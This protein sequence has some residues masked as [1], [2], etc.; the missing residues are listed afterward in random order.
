MSIPVPLEK[1]R[2]ALDE[3]GDGAYLLTVSDHVRPHPVHRPHPPLYIAANSEDSL[4]SA[5]RLGLPT[6]ASFFVPVAELERRRDL[7]RDTARG[8]GRP[9][10]E[11]AALEARGWGMRVVHVAPSR[12]EAL[13]AVEAPFMSYQG[14]M[15]M[16]RSDRTG[17][18][19]PNSFD[20]TLLRL[21][22]FQ[23]YLSDGWAL[24]GT[25]A[26]V[27]EGLQ[28]FLEATGS[29]VAR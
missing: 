18:S 11:I 29:P 7:Y 16:L 2:A 24:I 1:L 25:A 17:G 14:K 19:V 27:R 6:L 15:A 20:R 22:S 12:A 10:A 8:A 3:R 4:L 23:D 5:A 21:R 9:D 26:E 13:A 28:R